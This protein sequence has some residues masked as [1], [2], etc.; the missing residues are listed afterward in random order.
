MLIVVILGSL[1][2]GIVTV[3]MNA[4]GIDLLMEK[5]IGSAAS[6]AASA[7][8]WKMDGY[9]SPLKEAAAMD[10]FRNEEPTSE[11]LAKVTEDIADRNGFIYVGKM[12][13]TG[14]ASTG[15]NYGTM[16][17]FTECRDT[18]QPYITDLMKDGQRMVFILEV[19]IIR[20]GVFDGIAYGA[21][22]AV[23]LSDIVKDLG[24][25]DNG[26]A[27]I[28]DKSGTIIGHKDIQYV[29]AGINMIAAAQQDRSLS[30]IAG[31][32]NRM[33][34][35]ETGFGAYELFGDKKLAGYAPIGG[36]QDWSV[37][38]EVSQHE[39]KASLDTSIILIF[40]VTAVVVAAAFTVTVRLAGA[41]SD[42]IK[43]CVARL[44]SL[45]DG[46]LKSPV[47][48]F[49][50]EDETEELTN[51]L[52]TTVNA[53]A[54]M[55]SD[56]SLH[57]SQM[58]DGNFT[59]G[60]SGTYRG[61][62]EDIEKSVRSIHSSLRN[63][64]SRIMRSAKSVAVSA[65]QVAS[66]SQSLSMGA[67]E[68]AGSVQE[69]ADKINDISKDVGNNAGTAQSANSHAHKASTDIQESSIKMQQLVSA[70]NE[71]SSASD[72]IGEIIKTIEDIALRTNVLALNAAVEASRAGE[73]GKGFALVADEV[74]CLAS[75]SSDASKNTAVLIKE[76]QSA[77]E[78][79]IALADETAKSLLQ[80]VDSVNEVMEMLEQ[81][82][83]TSERQSESIVQ[84]S[85]GVSQI[86]GVVQSTSAASEE[87]A[88]A[89]RELSTQSNI[90]SDM[91]DKFNLK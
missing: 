43:A 42:P 80:T 1:T 91:V 50:S 9:W 4:H 63:M 66:G 17:Y 41:I 28:I 61:D 26:Y 84:I 6:M 79:S 5:T 75:R 34:N 76:S 40:I 32:H 30:D 59:E 7:V 14:T 21:V 35:G 81:I 65:E 73:A 83:A 64:L 62:F 71:V 27:Y 11:A 82:S 89:S 13:K 77:V 45:A 68:Q 90:M 87:S 24:V 33:I 54:D 22:N 19:P 2:I 31:I 37:C 39:F 67:A 55:V 57:L 88:A 85:R 12:D 72:K 58:A 48:H 51:A 86:S 15:E 69:L 74:R 52:D 46:D 20:D 29:E 56:V 38:I 18:M 49:A 47:P 78:R 16:Y 25:G 53:L 36:I 70:I 44:E 23:F 8:E 10:I 60:I 3:F